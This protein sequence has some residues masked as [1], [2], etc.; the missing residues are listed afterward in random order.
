MLDLGLSTA[1]SEA[2]NHGRRFVDLF[3]GSGVVGQWVAE[4]H[5]NAV[6][7]VDVQ[8]FAQILAASVVERTAPASAPILERWI[9]ASRS[10]FQA[11]GGD[12]LARMPIDIQGVRNQRALAVGDKSLGFVSRHYGGHYF[13]SGQAMA[14]DCLLANTPTAGAERV[15]ALA[16]IIESASLCAAAPGHTAQ[17]F[18]PTDRLIGHI[19]EAWR[20]DPFR[21]AERIAI[22]LAQRY[23]LAA[24][25]RAFKLPS[26]KFI[27]EELHAGSVV[28]C[29]PPYSEVQYS[30]FYHVL[31]GI[32]LGGWASVHGAGRAPQRELRF[33]S[34]FSSRTHSAA[35][36]T[37]LFASLAGK[38]TT[39]ILTFPDHECSN[40]QSADKLEALA[41]PWFDVSRSH[42]EMTHSSLGA[43]SARSTSRRPH[44]Q[45]DEALLILRS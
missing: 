14:L 40:G 35:A 10:Q 8:A 27:E 12:D 19:A 2:L 41:A 18:Q 42:I 21:Y 25:G 24:G 3:S 33:A 44:R 4:T 45:V 36:F 13:S 30:R 32:A 1:I 11:L 17:P 6:D 20:R 43:S 26:A 28:F 9:A 39:V 29:D 31:E 34:E 7:S 16:S 22:G 23:S 15:V 38:E 5:T 37:Q